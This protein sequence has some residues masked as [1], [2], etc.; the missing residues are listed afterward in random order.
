MKGT[1]NFD[2]QTI[3]FVPCQT[4]GMDLECAT[5]MQQQ[6]KAAPQQKKLAEREI[7]RAL[8]NLFS[9][10]MRLRLFDPSPS[11]NAWGSIS[12]NQV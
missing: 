8:H 10:R 7:D 12:A 4:G 9:V 1:S 11:G 2:I 5:Y 3:S 6:T